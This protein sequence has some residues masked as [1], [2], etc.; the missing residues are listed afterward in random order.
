MTHLAVSWGNDGQT[1][2]MRGRGAI[3]EPSSGTTGQGWGP[4]RGGR[5]LGSCMKTFCR[6]KAKPG[7]SVRV[8]YILDER[9]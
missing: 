8:P 6:V 9:G 1:V 3:T 2:A 5:T 4:K 7:P